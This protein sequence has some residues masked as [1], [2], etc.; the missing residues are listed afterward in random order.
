MLKK[1]NPNFNMVK[2]DS[3]GITRLLIENEIINNVNEFN[4]S[5][6]NSW[7][8]KPKYIV[9]QKHLEYTYK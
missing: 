9:I 7:S 2:V 5:I 8:T 4:Y 6:E 3:K 1:K